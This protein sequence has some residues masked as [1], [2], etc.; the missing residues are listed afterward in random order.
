MQLEAHRRD[1][2]EVAAGAAQRPEQL[3]LAVALS[4]NGASVREHNLGRLKIVERE[5]EPADERATAAAKRES[6]HSEAATEPVTGAKPSG[7]VAAT[8]SAA[9]APPEILA[10]SPSATA[11]LLIPLKSMR[12]PPHKARPA[13]S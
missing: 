9:R 6:S 8:T 4:D 10:V 2:S 11:T 1:D 7:S 5:P 3:L 12:T 13:Q